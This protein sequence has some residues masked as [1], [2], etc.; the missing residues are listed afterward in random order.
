MVIFAQNDKSIDDL[1]TE[2]KKLQQKLEAAEKKIKNLENKLKAQKLLKN[3]H[4]KLGLIEKVTLLEE[5]ISQIAKIVEKSQRVIQTTYISG[6]QNIIEEAN[7]VLIRKMKFTK[8]KKDTIL[9]IAL[10][11]NFKVRRGEA[12]LSIQIDGKT[13]ITQFF[14]DGSYDYTLHLYRPITIIGYVSDILDGEHTLNILVESKHQTITGY[15]SHYM[16]EVE[17]IEPGVITKAK[18]Q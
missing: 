16:L 12:S 4:S 10:N 5:K 2:N 3:D 15:K 13:Y 8:I 14:N 11:D 7:K 18:T 17:E 6:S 9:K 1:V